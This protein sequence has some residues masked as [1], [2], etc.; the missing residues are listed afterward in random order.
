MQFAPN[1]PTLID[2]LVPGRSLARNIALVVGFAVLVAVFAQIAIKLPFTTVPITGQTLAVLLTGGTLGMQLEA[3]R[4]QRDDERVGGG[5]AYKR[6]VRVSWEE[7]VGGSS[8]GGGAGGA[9]A[10]DGGPGQE[11]FD[12]GGA[13]APA[14]GGAAPATGG[15]GGFA[16]D[17]DVPF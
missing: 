1:A 4:A 16:E 13:A 5:F 9:G 7:P 14:A 6:G 15:G 3:L 11:A 2:S 10:W 12:A 17:D 8:G